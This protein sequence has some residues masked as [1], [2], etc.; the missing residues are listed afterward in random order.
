M[1]DTN[2]DPL[3]RSRG[4]KSSYESHCAIPQRRTMHE[5]CGVS[6]THLSHALEH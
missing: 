4:L 1:A 2:G 5:A 3:P 6:A